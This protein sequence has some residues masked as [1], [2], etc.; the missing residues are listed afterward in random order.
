MENHAIKRWKEPVY[1]ASFTKL[2]NVTSQK[3]TK[4]IWKTTKKCKIE[5]R[6]LYL[7]RSLYRKKY[8]KNL[9]Q[10]PTKSPY[11]KTLT[12]EKYNESEPMIQKNKH[13]AHSESQCLANTSNEKTHSQ[14]DDEHD[15]LLCYTHAVPCDS[16]WRE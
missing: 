4:K 6:M 3:C 9:R 14:Q 11:L 15:T 2:H 5:K 12:K 10:K 8:H 13:F 1:G 16:S 7:Y